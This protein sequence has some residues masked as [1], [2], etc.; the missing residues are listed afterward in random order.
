MGELMKPATWSHVKLLAIQMEKVSRVKES[1]AKNRL[2]LSLAKEIR[3]T[4]ERIK[5]AA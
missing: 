1:E 2:I 5:G 3:E 4:V